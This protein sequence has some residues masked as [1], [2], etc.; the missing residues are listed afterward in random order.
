MVHRADL[1]NALVTA[2]KKRDIALRLGCEVTRL[3]LSHKKPAVHLANGERI[4]GDVILGA[5]GERSFCRDVLL[6]RPDPPEPTGDVV[7]R[8]VVSRS[9]ITADENHPSREIVQPGS[10]NVW[11]GPDAHAVSYVLND[12]S[13]LLNVVLVRKDETQRPPENVMYGPQRA[14]LEELRR[15]FS[16]W[17]PA[18]RALMDVPGETDCAK[19]NLLR[20]NEVESWRHEGGAFALIG[21]A[22][23]G[24]PPFLAQGAAQ[25][26]ED[27]GFLGAIFARVSDA[28]QIPDALQVFEDGRKPRTDKVKRH[29]LARKEMYVLHD[30]PEQQKRDEKLALGLMKGSPDELADPDFQKWLWG[31]DAITDGARAW[32]ERLMKTRRT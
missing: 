25:A 4:E 28:A 8:I 18:L 26:F 9:D 6:G 11:V 7:F 15:A 12:N 19:W 20:I 21:D 13:D 27:A 22:A 30:G 17:D 14:S 24:M 31:Y 1:L 5:D 23:H 16:G 2:A 29:T 3:E 32:G 10:L